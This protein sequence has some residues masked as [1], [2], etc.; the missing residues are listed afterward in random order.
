MKQSAQFRFWVFQVAENEGA[1]RA[2]GDARG[3][4]SLLEA[5]DAEGTLLDDPLVQSGIVD[6]TNINYVRLIDI[7]GDGTFFDST[8]RPIY[9]PIAGNHSARNKGA[10]I[11]RGKYLFFSDAHMAYKP[12]FFKN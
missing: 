8:G 5:V 7:I 9:D 4:E 1:D 2:R 11:A 6:V 10:E 12:G 3:R